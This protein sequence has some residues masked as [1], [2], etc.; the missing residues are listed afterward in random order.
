MTIYLLQLKSDFWRVKPKENLKTKNS[1]LGLGTTLSL[2]KLVECDI[3]GSSLSFG[4]KEHW[5]VDSAS[6]S[7]IY[8]RKQLPKNSLC[9]SGDDICFKKATMSTLGSSVISM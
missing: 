5:L 1:G 4:I 8:I 6:I 3:C 2:S 9:L 7:S